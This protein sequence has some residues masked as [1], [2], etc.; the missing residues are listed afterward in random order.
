MV[1]CTGYDP[2]GVRRVYGVGASHDI[3]EERCRRAVWDYVKQR[4][5]TGPLSRWQLVFDKPQSACDESEL[6]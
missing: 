1:E 3:A 4:P 2:R 6:A 5:D